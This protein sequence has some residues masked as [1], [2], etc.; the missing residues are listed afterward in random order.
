MTKLAAPMRESTY[1]VL[2]PLLE[3]PLHGYGIVKRARE[4]S[5]GR[6]ELAVATLYGALERLRGEGFVEQVGEQIVDGR[7]RRYWRI[8]DAGRTALTGEAQR[9]RA[10]AIVVERLVATEA[11]R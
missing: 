5:G 11:A 1:F 6:V 3:G 7:A 2:A 10:A 9:L 8:T 4:L